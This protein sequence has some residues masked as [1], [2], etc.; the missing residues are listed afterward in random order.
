V[1]EGWWVDHQAYNAFEDFSDD[2]TLSGNGCDGT[3]LK[4][5]GEHEILCFPS[6]WNPR[7]VAVLRGNG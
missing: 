2:I 3:V 7:C 6:T 5:K 4:C 1:K